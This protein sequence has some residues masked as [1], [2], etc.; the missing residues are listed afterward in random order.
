MN[1]PPPGRWW[2]ALR[3]V[4]LLILA[5]ASVLLG[6]RAE[7]A[8][9]QPPTG[10]P[11]TTTSTTVAPPNLSTTSTT[12]PGSGH[13]PYTATF[14]P[15]TSNGTQDASSP[16]DETPASIQ[17]SYSGAPPDQVEL[18]WAASGR[19]AAAPEPGATS[20]T[21]TAAQGS[22]CGTDL[23]CWPWPVAM[24]DHSF[25][26]NGT[27]Q[28]IVCPFGYSRN[29][30]C[31]DPL[32]QQS[33]GVAVPPGEPTAVS[34]SSAGR[35]VTVSWHPPAQSPPDLVGYTV[36][37]DGRVIY[38]C[39]TDDLGPGAGT[40]CPSGLEV[41]DRPGDGEY[42]YTVAALRL[43][44]D[45]A[46]ANVVSS[47]AAVDTQ[48]VVTVSA[49][50]GQGQGSGPGSSAGAGS[51]QGTEVPLGSAVPVAG[52]VSSLPSAPATGSGTQVGVAQAVTS[53]PGP[54][55]ASPP[56]PKLSYPTSSD[57]V[58]AHP[59]ALAL[60]VDSPAPHEDVVPVAVLALGILSLAVA[61]H[62]LYLRVE[63]GVVQAR[64]SARRAT[65]F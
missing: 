59:Q 8:V 2:A 27:Y 56:I 48:G 58:P 45:D 5:G 10:T 35:K 50:S 29:G 65:G 11:T 3:W 13:A 22:K 12:A 41:S 25:I 42:T 60:K 4:A 7:A 1:A 51:G 32:P 52:T 19:S 24:E 33:V 63:L 64:H 28:L 15:C 44:V 39:S 57:V 18:D 40:P 43:G 34:A 46:A 21:L 26:L 6:A 54:G 9:A 49:T 38:T 30:V 31:S 14:V 53:A 23:V 47:P 17:V 37:R 55:A 16:C 61:A 20:V 36:A 62:F